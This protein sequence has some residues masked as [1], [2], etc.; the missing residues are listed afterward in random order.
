M[1][2]QTIGNYSCFFHLEAYRFLILTRQFYVHISHSSQSF[3][4][5]L[6]LKSIFECP[7]YLFL[8]VLSLSRFHFSNHISLLPSLLVYSST[9]AFSSLIYQN[10]L[11]NLSQSHFSQHGTFPLFPLL[12][13]FD[14][15]LFCTNSNEQFNQYNSKLF[16]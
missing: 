7:Y 11:I 12:S 13:C 10:T 4:K 15:M 9:L 1:S 2:Y 8:S 14:H 16:N 3:I 6:L 5:F